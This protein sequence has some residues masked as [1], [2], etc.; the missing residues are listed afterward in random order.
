[1]KIPVPQSARDE[2]RI[3]LR[4]RQQ[5]YRYGLTE[6]E[7]EAWGVAEAM[8]LAKEISHSKNISFKLAKQIADLYNR[9]TSKCWGVLSLCG[10][11]RW[12]KKLAEEV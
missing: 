1:M 8:D 7:A 5:Y 9:H 10:G 3:A 12:M 4:Q 6:H 11:R 2:A